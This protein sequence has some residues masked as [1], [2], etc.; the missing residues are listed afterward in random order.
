VKASFFGA[1]EAGGVNVCF[2]FG[3]AGAFFAAGFFAGAVGGVN[4]AVVVV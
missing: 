4:G 2:G 1:G 3:F